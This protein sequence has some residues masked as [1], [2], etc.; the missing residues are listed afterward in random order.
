MDTNKN[1][2]I[3]RRIKG[4][5]SLAEDEGNM[6]ES[7][8]AFLQ[9][10][11]I[12]VKYGVDPN[13]LDLGKEIKEI[14]TKSATQFKKLWW[15]ERSLASIISSNFRCTWHYNSYQHVRGKHTKRQVV[16]VGYE[17]D[18]ELATEMYKLAHS[19]T[20]FYAKRFLKKNNIKGHRGTTVQAKND[21]IKGFL[22][23]LERKFEEQ[24][25]EQ[26]WG[27]VV[28]VPKEVIERQDEITQGGKSLGWTV[29]NQKS[30]EHYKTGYKE[31]NSI[32][33]TKSTIGS[34]TNK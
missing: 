2:R 32:D 8:Q 30:H 31:G 4:L 11:E 17:Q 12:M 6:N 33:Y 5:L 15:W 28:V 34:E 14:L 3:I 21:Y 13:E 18:I 20:E 26:E 24:I 22:D 23:G 16:F 1:D 10:Q 27:L 29:P 25:N 19:A 7:Q 9:A